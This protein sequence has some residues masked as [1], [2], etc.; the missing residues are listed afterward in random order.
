MSY[1]ISWDDG[2]PNVI[3]VEVKNTTT[4]EEALSAQVEANK[5]IESSTGEC[6]VILNLTQLSG[7]PAISISQMRK[8]RDSWHP[9]TTNVIFVSKDILIKTLVATAMRIYQRFARTTDRMIMFA[10]DLQ[11]ARRIIQQS[12]IPVITT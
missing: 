12:H 6:S 2:S 9:R 7:M 10:P 8:H 4:W 5:M 3:L 1:L 11:D